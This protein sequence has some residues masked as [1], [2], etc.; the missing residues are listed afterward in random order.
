MEHHAGDRTAIFCADQGA[1]PAVD[2]EVG[3]ILANKA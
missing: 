3:G 1:L 2:E